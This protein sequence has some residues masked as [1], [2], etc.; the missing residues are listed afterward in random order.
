MTS[1]RVA[2][3]RFKRS[4]AF[5]EPFDP[6]EDEVESELELRAVVVG[7]LG[8]LLGDL[9]EERVLLREGLRRH[10]ALGGALPALGL[11]DDPLGVA[12]GERRRR[13]PITTGDVTP[14]A[15]VAVP[16]FV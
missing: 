14:V 13:S 10:E 15:P 1:R 11:R 3:C 5:D 12:E 4:L 8:E 16:E 9:E 2:G 6:V 7:R